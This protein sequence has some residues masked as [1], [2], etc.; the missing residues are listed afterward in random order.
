MT[1]IIGYVVGV[2][3]VEE[4]FSLVVAKELLGMCSGS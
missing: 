3:F 1:C 4:H 2:L